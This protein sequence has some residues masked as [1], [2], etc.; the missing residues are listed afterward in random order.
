MDVYDIYIEKCTA[1]IDDM[2]AKGRRIK[3]TQLPS[4]VS[5]IRKDICIKV[6]EKESSSSS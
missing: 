6:G 1:K 2:Y 4:S 5:E 3:F